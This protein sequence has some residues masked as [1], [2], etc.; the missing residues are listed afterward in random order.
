MLKVEHLIDYLKKGKFSSEASEEVQ[1]AKQIVSR[2]K[3]L[4]FKRSDDNPELPENFKVE[5]AIGG[6]DCFFDSVA[7]G[8]KRLKPEMDFTVKSL[9]EVCKRFA[10]NQLENDQSWLKGALRN[11]AEPI[12]VYV[13]RIEFTANDIEQK[14]GSVNVLG[15]TL[16]IW[17]RSEI[18]GRIIC[19]EYNV[20]LHVVEKH[21]VEGK[22][23]W[24]DQIVNSEGSRSMDSID[25]NEENTI[26]IINRGNA[27]FEPI[28]STQEIQHNKRQSPDPSDYD[29]EIT[30]EEE[31]INIIKSRDS[32]E[33]KLTKIRK[34]FEKEPKPNINFQGEDNGTPLHIVVRKKELKV[35]EWLVKNGA[36]IDIKNNRGR[37]PLDIAK[38]L[39]VQILESHIQQVSVEEQ[40]AKQERPSE[41]SKLEDSDQ[42]NQRSEQERRIPYSD[43][44]PFDKDLK[45]SNGN[46]KSIIESDI[47]PIELNTADKLNFLNRPAYP[48]ERILVHFASRVY[49]E[50]EDGQ[51]L[52]D[53]KLPEGWKLL[54]NAYNQGATNHY[55]GAAYWN[56]DQQQIVIAH[57][58][59]DPS[60]TGALW[61]D[62]R[63]I[64]QNNYVPQMNSAVT[65]ANKIKTVLDEFNKKPNINLQLSFTGHSLGGWLAQIT[66][67]TTKYFSDESSF[68]VKSEKVGYHAHTVAFDSPGSKDML[69]KIKSDFDLRHYKDDNSLSLSYLDITSYLS[70]PNLVNTC[71]LHLGTIYRVFIEDLP[72][73]RSSWDFAKYT[74]E[75]HSIVK[76]EE[77][78]DPEKGNELKAVID[79]PVV[80][81]GITR[82]AL[83][84]LL[85]SSHGILGVLRRIVFNQGESEQL[86]ER[87][88]Y[89]YFHKLAGDVSDYNPE[90]DDKEGY[91]TVRY[92]VQDVDK[93]KCSTRI[94]TQ[95]ELE[96]L[97]DYQKLRQFLTS[98][99][100]QGLFSS[101]NNENTVK[102]AIE[103]LKNF[104]VEDRKKTVHCQ[105]EKELDE[106]ITYVKNALYFF[107]DIKSKTK[108]VQT[109]KPIWFDVEDLVRPFTALTPGRQEKLEQIASSIQERIVVISGLGGVGKSELAVK[110]ARSQYSQEDSV[111]WINA[112][113]RETAKDSF[114]RLHK[115]LGLKIKDEDGEEKS[116]ELVIE[117]IYKHL[118]DGK[119][120][121]IFDNA[122]KYSTIEEFLPLGLS[123]NVNKPYVL[124]TSPN[125]L[126]WKSTRVNI[127]TLLLGDFT[128][129]EAIEF[130]K[131]ALEIGDDSQNVDITNL[132]KRL[133]NFPL[134]LQH[135]VTY[136]KD[137]SEEFQV[138]GSEFKISDYLEK[139]KQE[140]KKMLSIKS[141]DD[142]HTEA[143]F[144]VLKITID[145]IRDNKEYGQQALDMLSIV[146]YF[147]SRNIPEKTFLNELAS[148]NQ[149][150]LI[151]ITRL[152]K[153]YSIVNLEQDMLNVHGLVQQIRRLEL[154]DQQE[155]GKSLEEKTLERALGLLK[156]YVKVFPGNAASCIPHIISI[157]DYASKYDELIKSFIVD[158]TNNKATTSTTYFDLIIEGSNYE[159]IDAIIKKISSDN[160]KEVINAKNKDNVTPLHKAVLRNDEKIAKR[161]IDEGAD[162]NAKKSNDWTPLHLAAK[163]GNLEIVNALLGKGANVD[164]KTSS[165]YQFTPLHLAARNGHKEVVEA[166]LA[167]NANVNARTGY[168]FTPLHLAA[169]NGYLDVV[170]AL[171]KNNQIIINA[172]TKDKFTPLHLAAKSGHL[173]V[174]EALLAK[175]ADINA[176]NKDGFT[177]LHLAA[178]DGHAK[179]VNKLVENY[180]VD[181]DARTT[182]GNTPLHLAAEKGHLEIVKALTAKNAD[183]DIKNGDGNTASDLAYSEVKDYILSIYN[184][185]KG[186]AGIEG[187]LCEINLS[188]LLLLKGVTDERIGGFHLASNMEKADKFDDIVF[189][190][191]YRE[192]II[193]KSKIIF[194]QAKHKTD[195][196]GVNMNSLLSDSE[197]GDFSLKKY[198]ISYHKIKQ[199]F[200]EIKGPVFSSKF[201]DSEFIIY[202]NAPFTSADSSIKEENIDQNDFLRISDSQSKYYQLEFNSD[203][204]ERIVNLLKNSSD[205]RRLAKELVQ[206]I[207]SEKGIDVQKDIFKSYHIALQGKV[208]EKIDD[209]LEGKLSDNFL[210][211]DGS[212]SSEDKEFRRVFLEEAGKVLKKQGNELKQELQNKVIKL[213][214]R[215][216]INSGSGNLALPNDDPIA[217]DEIK[218]F[219][220][221]FKLFASQPSEKDLEKLIKDK[222]KEV[223]KVEQ[224]DI[225]SVFSDVE[226]RVKKW[227]QSGNNYITKDNKFFEDAARISVKFD[228]KEPVTLFTG[229]IRELED[230][231]K[232][233]QEGGEAVI[234]Q[235]ASV[236]GLGGIGKSE[237]ARKYIS[238]HNKDYDD[239]VIWINADNYLTI[240]ESFRR[241]A[242]DK[243]RIS[244]VDEN[245]KEKEIKLIVEDVYRFF[246]KRH[247]R[248][249]FVFDNAGKHKVVGQGEEAEGVDKF[250][251]S[252][253]NKPHVLITSRDQEWGEIKSLSLGVFTE[254]EAV[255]FIRK[256]LKDVVI[257]E[258]N[259]VKR[260]AEELQYLPLA[261]RQAVAYI[262]VENQ[263]L[264][265]WEERKFTISDYLEQFKEKANELLNK[266]SGETYDRYTETVM[267][268]WQ[269]TIDKIK[270]KMG[271]EQ[272]LEV[273]NIIAYLAPNEIP[274]KEVF[275]RLISNEGERHRAVELLDQYSMANLKGGRLN[276]HRLVQQVTR[277]ELEE[278][279]KE[280]E[281]LRKALT[282]L[283]KPMEEEGNLGN[284]CVSHAISAWSY[285]SEYNELVEEFSGLPSQVVN[286]L[287]DAAR[288]EEAYLFGKKA[289]ELLSSELGSKHRSTLV[290]QDGI[291]GVLVRQGKYDQAL[292]IY[293][294]VHEMFELTSG[295]DHLDTLSTK[296]NMALVLDK[297]GEHNE[298]LKIYNEV[299]E[300]FIEK[301]LSDHRDVLTVLSNIALV[302][303]NQGEYDK[304]LRIYNEV[305]KKQVEK[306]GPD[307]PNTLTILNNIALVLKDQ[308]KYKEALEIYND[309]YEKRVKNLGSDHPD[310]LI[311]WSGVASVLNKRGEYDNALEIYNEVYKKQV[312]KLGPDHSNTLIVR[313]DIALVLQDQGKYKEALEIYNDVCEKQVKNLGSNYIGTLAS[314]NNIASVL[315]KQGK[316]KEALK[317]YNDVYEKQ[318]KKLGSDN[319]DTLTVRNNIALIHQKLRE[320]DNALEIY[321]E[322]LPKRKKL[323]GDDHPDT[324]TTLNNVAGILDKRAEYGEA[325]K[326]Y[327]LV[328]EKQV[329]KFGPDHPKTLTTL[330]NIALVLGE[331]GK[332]DKALENYNKVYKVWED[333]LGPNHPNTLTVRNNIAGI[334]YKQGK[335][336]KALKVFQ[337]VYEGGKERLGEDHPGTLRVRNNIIAVLHAKDSGLTPLHLATQSGNLKT[338][339]Y[340]L[341]K[342]ADLNAK[343]N[344]GET[345]LHWA[346]KGG[347]QEVLQLLL[348]KQANPNI[349][350]KDGNTPLGLAY[351]KLAQDP[352]NDDLQTII[353]LLLS[354]TDKSQ[355]REEQTLG[356]VS[357]E[358]CL[359]GPS[360]RKKR[361]AEG[362]C[363]F[364]WEDVDEFNEE[365]DEIRDLSKIK[366]DS[367]KFI[368]YLENL[369]E[370]KR[371]QLIQLASEVKIGGNSQGLVSKLIS[372]QKVMSH[373]SRVGRISGMT[374]HGMMAKNVLVDFLN[375][376]YQGVAVNV[377]FI[378]GGQGF[379]K[380]AEAASLKG[381][382][383]AS[384]G[385][386]LLGRSLRAASPFLA[387]G[388]SA[389]VVYDL[390]NQ[391]KAFKNGTEEALV[392]IV[393][394]SIYLG[395]D[396]AEIGIEIAEAFEVLEGVSS[397]TGPIGATIGAVV[398]VGTDI[399][400]AVKR[401]DKI[402]QIIHLT[403]KE[404]FVEGLR[405]FIGM[406]PEKHIEELMEEKQVS[407]QLVK[408]GLEYLQQHSD[409]Q[410]YVFP[411]GK[412]VVDSCRDV[413]YQK[414]ICSGG[415]NWCSAR[416]TVTRYTEKCTTKFE[417]DLDST[418]LLDRKRTDI[419]WSRARPDNPS[420]G[421]L[422]CLPKGNDKPAPSYGSYLCENAIGLSVN[423]TGSHTLISLGEGKDYAKGF[424]NNPNIFVVNNGSKKYFGGNK[425][426]IFILQGSSITG[427]FYGEGGVNTLDLT[428]FAPEEGSIDVKLHI[429]QVEDYYRKNFFGMSGINKFLGRKAKADQVF[430]TCNSDTSD[431]KF[432]D[433][434]S[435]SEGFVDHINIHDED[436]AYEMQIVVRPN[437]VIYNRALK[438]DFHYIVPYALGSAKVD[439]IYTAE[440]LNLNNTFAF[441]YEPAQIKNVDVRNINVPNK[442][443]HI[444]TF[445]FSPMSDKEFNIT[446]SGASNPSY[447]LGNN[448]EI[449]VGNRGNLY[450]LENTNKSVNEIIKDYLVVAN[451]LN[452]MSF[453]IQSLLSNE[454]VAIGSGNYEVIHNNPLQKS[455][456]VGNGGENVYVIDSESK[457]FEIPLPEVVIYDLDVE[458]SVD[459]IDLKNLVQQAKGKFSNSFELQV[460][461]SANDLLLKAT[462]TEVKPTEDLPVNKIIKH[463]YFTV[464]LKDGINWYNKTHVIMDNVPMRINLDNNEWSLKPLPLV[465]EKD[466]E[467]IIVTSQ[468]VEENTELITPRKGG[469]YT[470]VRSNSND[471]MITNAFD[472]SITKNDLCSITLSK[473]YEE[474]KMGTLSIKFAD[475]EVV[476][477]EHQEEISSARDV[478]VVKK[479]YKDQVY[480][481]VFN[482]TKSS[483]EVIMLSDQP[484]A[485]KH[486]HS[487]RRQQTR[488]R[489]SENITSNGTR[490]S[491]WINDL[492]GWVKSSISGLLSSKSEGTSNTKSSISQ[493]DAKMDVNGTIMLLDVLVRKFTGKKYISGADQSVPLLEAR[494][495]ALNI[496]KGFEKVVEQAGLKSGVSMHRLN[497]DY[498]GMQKEIIR[499][500]MSGKFD[501]ISG[502]LNS[503]LEKACPGR[504]AGCPGKLSEKRF[505]EFMAKFNKGL[506]VLDTT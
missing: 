271:G 235:M 349:S 337:D 366:I 277:I 317:I 407:N 166:L 336:D 416:R 378:A 58:G 344:D 375:G 222:V 463:E 227:W 359:P 60:S 119:R 98:P 347:C 266:G 461:K 225:D 456:L 424:L 35:I 13:P 80:K 256:A 354:V 315:D 382:K 26:H 392:G 82:R 91:C 46:F 296:S 460:L 334:Y 388:T 481:D 502:I 278:K 303:D 179:I 311:S 505:N 484:M 279:N 31:L 346:A 262:K 71:C 110:Y 114:H 308:G 84:K 40:P 242:Q 233:L 153:K 387:R 79:W 138:R 488:H 348:N 443:S 469:N 30:P 390:V 361:N 209:K 232:I 188:M 258:E 7:Q 321:F 104:K 487:R 211:D 55:F 302:F 88:E 284:K 76:I 496:T 389:F 319:P 159:V 339:E 305:Y 212:L 269:I 50:R 401:V 281:V 127:G 379:A 10:Q 486:R 449:K 328:Y 158:S 183:I 431:I 107:P 495:Y 226:Y 408:Q 143:I 442:T 314:R 285:T 49:K 445:N 111:I 307:H 1:R 192:G 352:E 414:S 261:L 92:Q 94:F 89:E 283:K 20:K 380:V 149:E 360:H 93:K 470:F 182:N 239:N 155:E 368:R 434:Q 126:E 142:E 468:D 246:A 187:Q 329:E 501:E 160:L 312:E 485:H 248:S 168:K 272:A 327:D 385:K 457:R 163:N 309:V 176:Q 433:G 62:I 73:E 405:A 38:R 135:A 33:E 332:Y 124:I 25:Y 459:T 365:K 11:E 237:L 37:T 172:E 145:K 5:Q 177:P 491:S 439:F 241:L 297:Q 74:K 324:L 141:I 254:E 131:T 338:V 335:Y 306:L 454:T 330:N 52:P 247:R 21:V 120:L 102:K 201:E 453:F 224:Q 394:D 464:R 499:K 259:G 291:A 48:D 293:Q 213:S 450:M 340:V 116:I 96:F 68:F 15:L 23:V 86:P 57:R 95:P 75:T 447:R 455:H 413:P 374:M 391:V 477:K 186:A 234:S 245:G 125:N 185:T 130:V 64:L 331:E 396:A 157:W 429:G 190:Y 304:A 151:S 83:E 313:N 260:L 19:K 214:D 289:L 41:E 299:Y 4:R 231:H 189:K 370:E 326:I 263:G 255:E 489:R 205:S 207:S 51:E 343:N 471:L 59:T 6:G 301:F 275:S 17:G 99:Q 195:Q 282:L 3:A 156:E 161:M 193:E 44:L 148:G 253:A 219:L 465:F 90:P 170:Q 426:D 77:A 403:G 436:C 322:V 369:P 81:K 504:E 118:N 249:L 472:A 318:V 371:S 69:S 180:K 497:I 165:K 200:S 123:D 417:V 252:G 467:V 36:K 270:Q 427:Y 162:V 251:P 341:E 493:V 18:E 240:V 438:G 333:E 217:E 480:N 264:N 479:E 300:K 221:K 29:D 418:V 203:K 150:K 140:P 244:T 397:V 220:N 506:D 121:F 376:D 395:V 54:T 113:T 473:F 288:Y 128:D 250:L 383:L 136:I 78:L 362:E 202:T 446:I 238:K 372:N 422:F 432:V 167:K 103:A 367:K 63:G 423:K 154:G 230:L 476:L 39:N 428:S 406:Q 399:Y 105:S 411:T 56:P 122:E 478:N 16:P 419:R 197:S 404:K 492:F 393:G 42:K 101:F 323:L 184:R 280:R 109:R 210:S 208:I 458:S 268:T 435:G 34:L 216:G 475:K 194:L 171:L 400:M 494:G 444:I 353:G 377:G 175:S 174:I 490:P 152:L 45:L 451:R 12:S 215:F 345:A 373:L 70:A 295:S 139:Y 22:E 351:E 267:T 430:I 276:I 310:T 65:F 364:T 72:P 67:F 199:Q 363:L 87:N 466:K 2:R 236:T 181:I 108:N 320:Y 28:L 398:F 47:K 223:Y 147:M 357:A 287:D 144:K 350:D 273:L 381:L 402:D 134:A 191:E 164:D 169:G 420:N 85:S 115:K 173:S 8:L 196:K 97:R 265:K 483:P 498:M 386:L 440:A 133:H 462:V 441:E 482:H 229:R 412:S 100:L 206:S 198:F 500:V 286:K 503:H 132:V 358:E 243:L 178:L 384:E 106:L 137:A 43:K 112:E 298:A 415:F 448:T 290:I 66:T 355:Y 257:L 27:H 316:Y 474:P 9:R 32:E 61:T 437:T 342:G 356:S 204:K 146:S 218:D 129:T 410:S 24:L 294:K 452:K 228:V 274:I 14:S 292:E 325:L 409:I 425:D 53:K 117:E 421:K